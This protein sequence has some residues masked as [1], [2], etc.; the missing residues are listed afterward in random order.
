MVDSMRKRLAALIGGLAAALVVSL[1]AAPAHA[2]DETFKLRIHHFFPPTSPVHVNYFEPWKERVESASEGRIQVQIYPAMQLGGSPPSLYDQ[3]REGRADIIWTVLGYTPDRFPRIE[4]FDLP[5]MPLSAEITSQAAHAFAMEHMDE[6]LSDVHVIAVHV[7]SPGLL[8]TR[9]TAIRSLEDIEGMKIRGP[10][11]MINRFLT[12]LKAEPVGMPVPQTPEALSRGVIDGTVLPYEGI[13]AIGLTDL[14]SYHTGFAGDH[15]LYTTPM[16]VAMNRDSYESLPPELRRV[17][18]DNSG[19]EQAREI[20]RVMDE[21]DQ[22]VIEELRQSDGHEI[23]TMSEEE[24]ERWR[25][26]GRQVTEDWIADMDERGY[27]GSKLHEDARA[28]IDKYA[29]Q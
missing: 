29:E 28:L 7:H 19:I 12:A 16:L 9:D 27:D 1:A 4:V 24:T 25:E 22:P 18:D 26:I 17:I 13:D 2:E 20:G 10:S 11:R 5:F 14:T 6:S 23:I 15:A 21:A 8:H 3:A